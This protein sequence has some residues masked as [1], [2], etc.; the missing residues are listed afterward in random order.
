VS[1]VTEHGSW[2]SLDICQSRSQKDG[3]RALNVAEPE[4]TRY[5]A[6]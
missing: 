1:G 5:G 3:N 2:M 6:G 4:F